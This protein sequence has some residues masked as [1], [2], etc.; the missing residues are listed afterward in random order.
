MLATY[1]EYEPHT[2]WECYSP[3]KPMPAT[4]P[5]HDGENIVRPDFC[6]WSALGPISIYIEYVL[7]FH[8]INAFENR[9]EWE[10][11]TCFKGNIGVKNL[12]FG[13]VVTDII[14]DGKTCAVKSNAPYTLAVC[15]KEYAIGEGET[16]ITI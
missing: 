13:D 10:M 2:I 14:S 7:G 6:G 9:V 4:V 5:A 16:N 11:P 3:T 8:T 1:N 12:R 15:G